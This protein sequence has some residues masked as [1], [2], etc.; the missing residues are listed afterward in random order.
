M[1]E[2]KQQVVHTLLMNGLRLFPDYALFGNYMSERV[3]SVFCQN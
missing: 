1:P 2:P 3:I